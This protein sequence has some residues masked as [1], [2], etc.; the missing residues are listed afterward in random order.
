MGL[1]ADSLRSV[2][3]LSGA[4]EEAILRFMLL[5]KSAEHA[6][7][8]VFWRMGTPPEWVIFP[9]S[10]EAKTSAR[11]PDGRE[12]ID[13]L[14][15]AGE[16]F[17]L[18]SAL[19]GHAHPTDAEVVRGGEFFMIGREP[20]IQFVEE[21]PEIRA[22][23]AATVAEYYRRSLRERE[24]TALYPVP[25]R[26]AEFLRRHAC[27]RQTGGAR[28]L[29]RG[30]QAE[31]AA[32]LGTVREVIA[33]VL[34]GLE[35][36]GIIERRE[37]A[38]FISDWEALLAEAKFDPAR[39]EALAIGGGSQSNSRKRTFRFFLPDTS[40]SQPHEGPNEVAKC[41]A[42]LGDLTMCRE[43]RCPAALKAAQKRA[44]S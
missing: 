44:A 12:F 33:R 38:I 20:F 4:G 19:D 3:F 16:C 26:L 43:L 37:N 1:L 2:D 40:A 17:G 15:G 9:V 42:Y 21:R 27:Q 31:L 6:R 22:A 8:H 32:R 29:L 41:R 10:G 36:R 11:N 23:A 25:E 7:G 39:E 28:V 34:S 5:G 18:A 30:T 24:D 35:A 14:L 13:R